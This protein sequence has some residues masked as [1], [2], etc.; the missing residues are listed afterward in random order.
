MFQ[1]IG[2]LSKTCWQEFA[3]IDAALLVV[4]VD[5]GVMPQTR[6]HLAILDLLRIP[7]G[8]IALTKVDVL[9][10]D[11][12]MNA[13]QADIRRVVRGTVLQDAQIIPVSARTGRGLT[14][15]VSA[16][17]EVLRTQPE[18]PDLGRPRLPIDRVFT[19]SGFGTVVTGTL[20][21]G[22][23]KLGDELEVVPSGLRGR[24]R[25][26]QTHRKAID[27][28][29]P[30]SRT[31]INISG[32]PAERLQRGQVLSR[33]GSYEGTLRLDA[34]LRV[35]GDVSRDV[36][37]NAEV[38]VFL[39]TTE[40]LATLRL[41]D[42]EVLGPGAEGWIQL[43]LREP[44]VCVRGDAFIVRWPSPAETIGGGFVVDPHP[45]YRHKRHE[46]SVLAALESLAAGDPAGVLLEATR[47]LGAA[48]IREI[49]RR[50][51][52]AE[53]SARVALGELT[54]S[55]KLIVLEAGDVG[56]QSD[57][58]TMAATDWAALE[59]KCAGIVAEYH[60]KF[61]LRAGIPR[62]ELKSQL[63]RDVRLFNAAIRR[64]VAQDAL[65]EKKHALASPT[66]QIHLD[67]RQQATADKLMAAFARKPYG[68]PSMREC[69]TAAGEEILGA[70]I[71]KGDLVP[72]SADI[73]FRKAD[74]DAMVS[75]VREHLQSKG[76]ITLG[77]VRDQFQ[78]SRKYAQALLEHLDAIGTTRR[79]GDA[80]VLARL[81][82]T[83]H[84][85]KA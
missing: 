30:G 6:E 15:L 47:S 82:D 12:Q 21:D 28:A 11:N 80:R 27:Q 57:L 65:Q 8:V 60:R 68:P 70:L 77:E 3:G 62:E 69:Q 81:A 52:L 56:P 33:P 9:V 25:G 23:L 4:A 64:L 74:Y 83:A 54:L 44:L 26:I 14:E 45:L 71:A 72:V 34:R 50:S 24:V 39:G 63:G 35:L 13:V 48:S 37:H 16:L 55:G 41:L 78:T 18:R 7:T 31:A 10:E 75:R 76:Q 66:H 32:V 53:S 51:H 5:E 38:K 61:P 46:V 49:V 58:L 40:S 2:I 84:S 20:S 17:A 19:M 22:T 73:L 43:E 67:G 36:F 42:D 85:G 59:S 1:V 79:M 29:V